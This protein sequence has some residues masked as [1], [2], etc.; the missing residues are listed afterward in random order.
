MHP[1]RVKYWL[2]PKPADP[3]AFAE[4]VRTVCEAY[5]E[6]IPLYRASGVHTVS[7]DEQTGIQAL[8]RIALDKPVRPGQLAQ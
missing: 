5:A 6:A 8:E 1:H 7:I 3:I 4:Q 2:N